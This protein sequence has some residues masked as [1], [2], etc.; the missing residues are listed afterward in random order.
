MSAATEPGRRER[1]KAATRATIATAALDL[2]LASGFD[3]VGIRDIAKQADVALATVFAHFPSKEAL[4]FDDDEELV[5]SLVAALGR[6]SDGAG[7]V[8][9]LEQWF[10]R[11]R[12]VEHRRRANPDFAAFRRL[13]EETP[14]LR[15]YW[16]DMWRRHRGDVADAIER[17]T[18]AD[19]RVAKLVAA[20]TI[21][22]YLLAADDDQ[23]DEVLQL[24]FRTLRG[25]LP[26]LTGR[27]QD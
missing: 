7:V 15:R 12:A 11:S 6:H 2:F 10:M 5:R 3:A 16:E 9:D 21:E 1:K 20:L 26:S 14:A 23:P 4:V 17:S 27:P 19:Q 24:L 25:G 18:G 22:G 8:D 13:V